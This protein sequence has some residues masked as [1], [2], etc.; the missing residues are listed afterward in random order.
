MPFSPVSHSSLSSGIIQKG[1]E[2]KKYSEC[3]Y[4]TALSTPSINLIEA[5]EHYANPWLNYSKSY[6]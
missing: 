2:E 4:I 5:D 3:P 6:R 1:Q